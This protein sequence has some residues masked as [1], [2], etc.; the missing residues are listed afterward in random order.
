MH[1]SVMEVRSLQCRCVDSSS[2]STTSSL[3]ASSLGVFLS[4][5]RK[6][7]CCFRVGVSS[8]I[9]GSTWLKT[10]TRGRGYVPLA[11]ADEV[12]RFEALLGG[13]A[14]AAA[15]PQ[16]RPRSRGLQE[17]E[18]GALPG[19]EAHA[20]RAQAAPRGGPAA[21]APPPLQPPRRRRSTPSSWRRRARSSPRSRAAVAA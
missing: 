10:T 19:E 20:R 4:W 14:C 8:Q 1:V 17:E 11:E 2:R 3:G 6:P 9:R 12:D 7:C 21:G 15:G 13:L 18:A 16:G 5:N